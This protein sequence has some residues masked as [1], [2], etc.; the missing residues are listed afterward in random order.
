MIKQQKFNNNAIPQHHETIN[1]NFVWPFGET[2]NKTE[3]DRR[4]FLRLLRSFIRRTMWMASDGDL[5]WNRPDQFRL[6]HTSSDQKHP[7]Q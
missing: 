6:G 7:Y 2:Y 5:L 3:D 4:L 1:F